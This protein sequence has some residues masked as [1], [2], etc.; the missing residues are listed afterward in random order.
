MK[1]TKI[2]IAAVFALSFGRAYAFH[3][4]GV[5]DC[6]GCH[7]MHNSTTDGSANA[8]TPMQV[9]VVGTARA[10]LLQG[11][12]VSSTCLI[13]HGKSGISSYHVYSPDYA[14]TDGNHIN[15]TP[16][17]DFS[18][19]QRSFN[20][21][22]HGSVVDSPGMRHGHSIV[23]ADVGLSADNRLLPPGSG[24]TGGIVDFTQGFSGANF[25]CVSC[26]NPH[27]TERLGPNDAFVQP[28]AGTAGLP[29]KGSG[30]YS[31]KSFIASGG[32]G[33]TY[34]AGV[35]RLLGGKG[36]SPKSNSADAFTAFNNEPPIALAPSGYNQSESTYSGAKSAKQV[37]V[38]YGSGM[39]EWCQNC[40]P[41][42]HSD[43][44]ASASGTYLRH[45]A[46]SGA[47]MSATVQ[48]NYNH[49]VKSGDLSATDNYDSLI[50]FET[51]KAR[52][53]LNTLVGGTTG[54]A[55]LNYYTISADANSNPMCLS[56][57]RA[58]ASAF[59][60]MMRWNMNS[61]FIVSNGVFG[62]E[63]PGGRTATDMQAGMYMRPPTAY[64]A[65]QRSLCNKCH[66]KD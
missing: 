46:G 58:H 33:T 9:G 24:Q 11:S 7:T 25:S 56:C 54:N 19:L 8:S 31:G 16:G 65:Y 20:F 41:A 66:A 44:T 1:F 22:N 50:P 17:G 51:G 30:S 3:S 26:H 27:G 39:S 32:D 43:Q 52:T 49:Y 63:P 37:I 61:E 10:F 21:T 14:N 23:A 53:D 48:S 4:G 42:M 36:W 38:A 57:H 34:T 60:S 45:P 2:A 59:D 29:I 35:Y 28:A 13:C 62:A 47:K 64:S 5:A 40:H 12:D 6:D 15:Y 55:A 18:W